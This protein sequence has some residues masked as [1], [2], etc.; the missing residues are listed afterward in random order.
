MIAP[1]RRS[2]FAFTLVE[3]LVVVALVAILAA[4]L[5]PATIGPGHRRRTPQAKMEINMIT[6]AIAAYE[7]DYGRF[8][9]SSNAVR[10]AA[11]DS[12]DFT[13]GGTVLKAALGP[14]NWT[15]DNSEVMVVL[16]DVEKFG[17][18]TPTINKDYA[19]NPR[20]LKYMNAR[21]V[22]DNVSPGIGMDGVYRDPWGSPY[23][24]SLDLNSNE[25]CRDAFYALKAVSQQTGATGFDGLEN[26]NDSGG[27]GDDFEFNCRIMVWS[28]GPDKSASASQSANTGPNKD[29]ILSWKH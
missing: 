29:N 24:I 25:R 12:A 27:A 13:Y 10:L 6:S 3:L 15:A 26:S 19:M 23:I 8:P 11:T 16:L 28:L 22:S 2:H 20:R 14:G 21:M 1:A 9:V 17:N 4:L 7:A 18:G 5:M